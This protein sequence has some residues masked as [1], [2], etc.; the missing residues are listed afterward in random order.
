MRER[1][2]VGG[3]L[4]GGNVT[5]RG[6][7]SRARGALA[8]AVGLLA[9]G[10]V[11]L[12]GPASGGAAP[13]QA[14]LSVAVT[15]SPDPVTASSAL[16]YSLTVANAGPDVAKRVVLTDHLV[17]NV[18]F[19]GTHT[20]QGICRFHR[21]HHNVRCTLRSLDAGQS[22]VVTIRVT[23]PPDAGQI[24]SRAVV[25]S[26]VHDPNGTNNRHIETTTV[27]GKPP[28]A[29]CQGERANIRGT[30]GDDT[31]NGHERDDV[32]AAFGGN[33]RIF[34]DG[35]SDLVC[36]AGG[37]DLVVAGSGSDTI[38]GG[39]QV[40]RIQGEGGEDNLRGGDGPDVMLGG[41][42]ADI[43]RGQLGTDVL[44]GRDGNDILRGG[45]KV[46]TLYGGKGNDILIGGAGH[47]RCFGGA[48]HN[49]YI[50]CA[51]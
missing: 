45:P 15:D 38:H 36:A 50:H 19:R 5:S 16:T 2:A 21:A 43:L 41:D 12:A 37:D 4:Q 27:I 47:D 49:T 32:V 22:I 25:K 28:P 23:A 33:D 35:G 6:P 17:K 34:P 9:A 48:G 11:I 13:P 14:D 18:K 29:T 10:L 44:R 8:T 39:D 26:A 7:G 3:M 40:D 30:A 42:G 51:S 20:P 31:L 1:S 24:R 46:D